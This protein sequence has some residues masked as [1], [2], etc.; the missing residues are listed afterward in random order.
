MDSKFHKHVRKPSLSPSIV[1]ARFFQMQI[2]HIQICN[3]NIGIMENGQ[4]RFI[5]IYII[6][7]TGGAIVF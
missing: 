3:A 6:I 1:I 4:D 2:N 5:D 7:L